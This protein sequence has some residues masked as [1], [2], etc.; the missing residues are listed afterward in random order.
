MQLLFI[1]IDLFV[2]I[3]IADPIGT[4]DRYK[5]QYSIQTGP[6]RSLDPYEHPRGGDGS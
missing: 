2:P 5:P 3:A 1:E 4:I 6:S